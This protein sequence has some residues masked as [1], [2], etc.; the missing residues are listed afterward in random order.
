MADPRLVHVVAMARNR[1]IG[2]DGAM[3]WRLP[4]D[5]KWFK[6]RTLGK[7][8]IMGR[9]T[10]QSI[11]RPLPRRL[12]IV[13][14][15][16]P[17]FRPRNIFTAQ[18]IEDAIEKAQAHPFADDVLSEICI[19][20]G[21]EI[22]RQTHSL[23]SRLYLTEIEAEIDGDTVYPDFDSGLWQRE[24]VEETPADDRNSHA[25][26]FVVLDRLGEAVNKAEAG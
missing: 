2:R 11:G 4:R 20:G 5:L 12:N 24:I 6:D 1:V 18:T 17:A 10:F 23:V 21:G 15:G 3:P 26:R 16:D 7:P 25:C 22:Y 9:K 19:I 14:S 13:V 8:V